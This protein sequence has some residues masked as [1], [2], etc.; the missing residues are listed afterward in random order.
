[1]NEDE[2]SAKPLK[3]TTV[4]CALVLL[5]TETEFMRLL[6]KIE[7]EFPESKVIY[8]TTSPSILWVMRGK[9][10]KEEGQ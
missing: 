8:K 1:M 10:P 2:L 7:L 5:M 9:P 3:K 6:R 4:S